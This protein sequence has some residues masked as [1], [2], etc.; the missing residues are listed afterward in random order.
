MTNIP[1]SKSLAK[2]GLITVV[3]LA[4]VFIFPRILISLLGEANPWTSYLYQYGFGL[5]F[6]L[7]G[8]YIIFKSGSCKLGRGHDSFWFGVL[9]GGFIFFAS[10]HA[11]WIVAS[12]TIPYAGGQ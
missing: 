8:I 12:L 6:F 9:I 7:M 4:F 5:I 2:G 10:A 3:L 11:L 1:T